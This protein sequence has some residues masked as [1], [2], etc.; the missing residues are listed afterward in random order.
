MALRLRFEALYLA[1]IVLTAYIF[2]LDLIA[3][4][5]SD[6]WIGLR[7]CGSACAAILALGV[8]NQWL[9]ARPRF[10]NTAACVIFFAL[11]VMLSSTAFLQLRR[12]SRFRF[13]LSFFGAAIITSL[14]LGNLYQVQD[15]WYFLSRS[16][17]NANALGNQGSVAVQLRSQMRGRRQTND[18]DVF[19]DYVDKSLLPFSFTKLRLMCV[20]DGIARLSF[21][22]NMTRTDWRALSSQS[23]LRHL[24]FIG[25]DIP[26]SQFAMIDSLPNLQTLSLNDCD[27]AEGFFQHFPT[28]NPLST[29]QIS[30][31]RHH[32]LKGLAHQCELRTLWIL[33]SQISTNDLVEIAQL[34]KLTEL[35]LTNTDIS[36]DQVIRF[37]EALNTFKNLR[38]VQFKLTMNVDALPREQIVAL[39]N[40]GAIN[41][42]TGNET[43][44]EPEDDDLGL[45]VAP[46]A[47]QTEQ[48]TQ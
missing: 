46:S 13:R 23:Q 26:T 42:I 12:T 3:K 34:P 21:T 27:I 2:A 14:V 24:E 1:S 47:L 31:G 25:N 18:L 10:P 45:D 5:D 39:L 44:F 7:Q 15:D 43:T 16:R 36:G 37:V 32:G 38:R 8:A 11:V 20:V 22:G 17:Q 9:L 6:L 4:R 48:P 28:L 40:T 35:V 30:G 33:N 19:F 29:L 41:R